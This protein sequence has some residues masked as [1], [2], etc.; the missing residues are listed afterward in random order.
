MGTLPY[1]TCLS[2]ALEWLQENPS[3][4]NSTTACVFGLEESSLRVVALRQKRRGSKP[5]ASR[6]GSQNKVLSDTQR[7]AILWYIREQFELG[8][9][10]TKKMIFAAITHLKQAETPP[11]KPPSRRWFQTWLKANPVHT[12]KTKPI[13][14]ARVEIHDEKT[15][16][17]WFQKL[18]DMLAKRNIKKAKEHLQ[19]WRIRCANWVPKRWGSGCSNRR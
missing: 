9:G 19:L 13:S 11:K 5:R 16:E 1:K 2:Q 4:K 8:F 7:D 17:T 3:E 12:I 15:V 6:R 18:R 10:A 14:S